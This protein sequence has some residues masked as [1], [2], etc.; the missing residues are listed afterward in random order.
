MSGEPS[1][2]DPQ[3]LWQSQPT[4]HDAMT[5]AAIHAKAR[6]LETRVQVRNAVEYV[7]CGAAMVGFAPALLNGQNWMI[8]AGAALIMLGV[9]FIAWQLHRRASAEASPQP[10]E[11]LV[12]AYRRQLVRQR[13]ALRSVGLW[14]IAPVVPGMV[15]FMLGARLQPHPHRMPPASADAA[16]LVAAGIVAF[17]FVG[18]WLLN[19]NAARQLQKR[20]DEL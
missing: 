7:A 11:T 15:L 6:T 2:L 18:V 3:G 14:Y 16:F 8:R 19:L 1:G 17:V 13:D 10:G 5:L 12:E 9:V 20:I 4:E